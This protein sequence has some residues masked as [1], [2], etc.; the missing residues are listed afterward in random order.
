MQAKI[1]LPSYQ[2][3]IY[4]DPRFPFKI[5]EY[6]DVRGF[7]FFEVNDFYGGSDLVP[8]A[9]KRMYVESSLC[10]DIRTVVRAIEDE[11]RHLQLTGRLPQ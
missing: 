5:H 2:V 3:G 11:A 7:D 10:Y 6:N 1:T 8:A 9:I 4:K